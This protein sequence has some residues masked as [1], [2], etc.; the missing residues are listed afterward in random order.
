M[1]GRWRLG[2][3]LAL[4]TA[5]LWGVL[6]VALKITLHGMDGYTITW[7]RFAFSTLVVGLMLAGTGSLPP[8]RTL[9][10]RGWTLLLIG[11]GGLIGNYLLY[12][13]ALG[14]TTPA[15]TQ[16]VIQL[17]PMFLLLGGLVIF[18]E[19]FS[20][21]QWLGFAALLVGLALFFNRRLPQLLDL[22]GGL[23]LGVA[24]IVLASFVWAAYGLAQKQLLKQLRSQQILWILYLAA[25]IVLL[26]TAHRSARCRRARWPCS[27]SA[28]STRL[29]P[30]G[31]S[32]K[33]CSIGR[34]PA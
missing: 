27:S 19:R 26:P 29:L 1:T 31:R 23:G 8:V 12:V 9:G 34:S 5:V 32:P 13:F 22:H 21:A 14:H 4:T 7:Y 16:T 2:L 25:A 33:R 6:P 15:V 18:R 30:T 17:A 28:Q 20:L 10:R 3:A 24:L 11:L